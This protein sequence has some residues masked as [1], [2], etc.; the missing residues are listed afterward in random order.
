MTNYPFVQ[1]IDY[2]PRD[3]TLGI[4][5]HMSEGGDGLVGFLARHAGEDLHQW[6]H[7]VNGVSCNVAILSTGKRVQMLPWHHASGNLNPDDRAGEYGYY[8]G[9]HLREVLGD[10]WRDPNTWTVSAELA[11]RRADGPTDAQ[12]RSTIEWGLEMA[13]MFQT[14]RGTTGHHDQSPKPCP[15]LTPNMKAIFAG[16]GGHGLWVPQVEEPMGQL[17]ITDQTPMLVTLQQP[18]AFYNLDGSVQ[19]TGHK[20]GGVFTSPYQASNGTSHFRAIYAGPDPVRLVLIKPATTG[21]VPAPVPPPADCKTE[22]ALA[23]KAATDPLKVELTTM[24][25]RVVAIKKK[26]ADNAADVA[27]D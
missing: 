10:H 17:P 19:S 26:V 11:G 7:R 8:G 16:L 23:V 25:K 3:G 9:H 22:V 13:D 5:L 21:P 27:D 1:G 20:V 2:G 6:A 14:I 12:V 4:S 24:S 15:G 18:A